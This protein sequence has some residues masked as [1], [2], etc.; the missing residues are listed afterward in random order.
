MQLVLDPNPRAR[1]RWERKMVA[2]DVRRRG[3]FTKTEQI[4]RT[5]RQATCRSHWFLTSIKKLTPLARQIAGKRIEDAIV[6]M[7]LSKKKAARD[8]LG[9]LEHARDEAIVRWGMGMNPIPGD[10]LA[11]S[12]PITITL[13]D[14][15]RRRITNPTSIYIAQAWVNRGPFTFTTSKRARGRID[16]IN[17]PSTSLSVMLKE[18]RTL[19]RQWKD[20]DAAALRKRRAQLWTQLPDRKIYAQNQYYSW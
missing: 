17:H 11:P 12:E 7:R 13:K 4:M 15:Q 5:E 1:I 9:H 8:V 16:K 20:L 10:P 18:E 2:R 6:Q 19:V 3:R 14:G